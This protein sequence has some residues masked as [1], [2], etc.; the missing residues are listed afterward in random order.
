M[1]S[2]NGRVAI[3]TGSSRAIGRAVAEQLASDG[4]SV[5]LNCNRSRDEAHSVVSG[6]EARGGKAIAIQATLASSRRSGACFG[7]RSQSSV[8]SI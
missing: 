6:I 7:K 3:D 4:A 8:T 2:L 5:V 1:S